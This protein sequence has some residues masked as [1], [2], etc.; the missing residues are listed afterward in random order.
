MRTL[1]TLALV[2]ALVASLAGSAAADPARCTL[3][4]IKD[5]DVSIDIPVDGKLGAEVF[6]QTHAQSAAKQYALE[7]RVC[8]PG[9][10]REGTFSITVVWHVDKTDKSHQLKAYCPRLADRK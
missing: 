9:N 10:A 1:T 6:C 5:Q 8:Q 3:T 7:H 2:L 4:R